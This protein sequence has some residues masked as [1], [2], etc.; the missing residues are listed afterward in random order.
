MSKFNFSSVLM[1]L[2]ALFCLPSYASPVGFNGYY[3]YSTWT[4]S[5]TYGGAVV[6]S[7]D[8]TQQTLTL[9]E[10]D[11]YPATPWSPQEF[12]FSH[13][14]ADSGLIS[15]DWSF[16]ANI[17]PCCSGLNFY[18]NSVLHNLVGGY[19]ANPYR[20]DGAVLSGSFSTSVNVGDT[21]SFAAFSADSCCGATTNVITNFNAPAQAPEPSSI[22]LLALGLAGLIKSRQRKGT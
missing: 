15:F 21:I 14:V 3:D 11:S 12:T 2:G 13:T 6:S 4:S 5:E 18:I 16:D 10:P 7:I 19:M 1:L 8:G 17:D 22:A 20:W 9:M